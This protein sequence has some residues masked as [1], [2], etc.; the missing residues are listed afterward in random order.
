M[1]GLESHAMLVGF[2]CSRRHCGPLSLCSLYLFVD[3][4]LADFACSILHI[5][6]FYLGS[7]VD[8]CPAQ[9]SLPTGAR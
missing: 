6:V 5:F 3:D 9:G 4:L 1:L 7:V 8:E 2:Q